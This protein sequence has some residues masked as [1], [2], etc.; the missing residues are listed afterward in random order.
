MP[1]LNPIPDGYRSITPYLAVRG[2]AKALEFYKDE[3]WRLDFHAFRGTAV[4]PDLY[5]ADCDAVLAQAVKAGATLTMPAA[6][7]F[8]GDRTTRRENLKVS[9]FSC[10]TAP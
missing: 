9:L 7:Q 2:D 6:D 10:E 8:Y 3:N 1:K 4:F 5:V